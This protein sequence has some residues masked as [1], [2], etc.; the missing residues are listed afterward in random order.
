MLFQHMTLK[1]WAL[2]RFILLFNCFKRKWT[3]KNIGLKLD[4]YYEEG[5]RQR[6]LNQTVFWKWFSITNQLDHSSP[7]LNIIKFKILIEFLN[8]Y[9]KPYYIAI[10]CEI[11][12]F[13]YILYFFSIFS[14]FQGVI[15]IFTLWF[16]LKTVKNGNTFNF[17]TYSS[18]G[19]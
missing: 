14:D 8:L 11:I 5:S 4:K 15:D 3:T 12:Q 7:I 18:R 13:N 19:V 6:I 16:T 10:F 1:K 17:K 2:N 9:Y